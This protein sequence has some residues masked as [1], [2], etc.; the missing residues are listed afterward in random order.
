MQFTVRCLVANVLCLLVCIKLLGFA[1][2]LLFYIQVKSVLT[3]FLSVGWLVGWLV[4]WLIDQLTDWLIDWWIECSSDL[5]QWA[6]Y[7]RKDTS[8][9][10]S[11]SWGHVEAVHYTMLFLVS[12]AHSYADIVQPVLCNC[13]NLAYWLKRLTLESPEVH[14]RYDMMQL[15]L[16]APVSYTHLTLPTNRE[17]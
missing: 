16:L 4:D 10:P 2:S 3:R 11:T 13:H 14:C 15:R 9:L 6:V 17:V 12:L 8:Q 5:F 1:C 7:G